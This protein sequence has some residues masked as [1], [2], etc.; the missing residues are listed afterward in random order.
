[1]ELSFTQGRWSYE[2]WVDMTPYQ[3]VMQSLL[4][5]SFGLFLMCPNIRSSGGHLKYGTLPREAVCTESLTPWLKLLPCRD[6]A[7]LSALMD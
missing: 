4:E 7:G 6:K 5:L 1:M 2:H 3:V